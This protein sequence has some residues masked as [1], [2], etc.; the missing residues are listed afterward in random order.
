MENKKILSPKEASVFLGVSAATVKNWIKLKKLP[1]TKDGAS[2]LIQ[3][4]DLLILQ[5]NMDKL[6][7]L[8]SRRNKSRQRVNFIP[9][10]Y[11]S[12]DSPNYRSICSLM[13]NFS[14]AFPGIIEILDYYAIRLMEQAGIP[15]SISRELVLCHDNFPD[16]VKLLEEYPITLVEGEDTL[17]M[18]YI[19]LR[20]MQDKK[21]TGSYYTPCHVADLLIEKA[22]LDHNNFSQIKLCDPSCGS[23]NFLIRLPREIALENI[24]G[25]DIDETAISLARINL[26]INFRIETSKELDSIRHNIVVKDYLSAVNSSDYSIIIGNPPWGYSYSQSEI[27][28]LKKSFVTPSKLSKPESF[29]LFLEKSLCYDEVTFLLP[30]T[31]LGSDTH[32]RIREEIH[33]KIN[34][35]SISYLGEVFDKVQCPCIILNLSKNE[36]SSETNVNFYEKCSGN[37]K[38]DREFSIPSSRL[39]EISFHALANNEEYEVLQKMLSCPHF[40]LKGKA[41]FALGIVTGNNKGLLHA[42][43]MPGCEPIIKGTD[44]TKYALKEPTN[45]IQSDISSF[46]QAA[47]LRMY[48]S[49]VKLVY[50]F[51]SSGLCF[52]LDDTG[53]LTLNSANILIPRTKEY[54]AAYIMAVLNSSSMAFYYAHTFR[55]FKVLRSALESLPIPTCPQ[56]K[57]QEISELSLKL[58]DY[59]KENGK[60]DANLVKK[61]DKMVANLYNL[62]TE[63]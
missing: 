40:T 49:E 2:F 54:S 27:S 14:E 38:V 5:S 21:S 52:A 41:D 22:L 15:E 33:K 50:K 37:L 17:G 26:A 28:R 3:K 46:Q 19:S 13:D 34:I 23:G 7:M 59:T 42:H 10:N 61:L 11:I 47:P 55:N 36:G 18:L 45:Y 1:A 62:S 58:R 12:K 60:P 25:C 24:F 43:E 31:L 35:K 51:I 48:K 6:Q 44:I 4:K 53:L 20:R 29:S 30:E 32:R 63:Y 39:T 8:N 56:E 9:G 57:M 16:S